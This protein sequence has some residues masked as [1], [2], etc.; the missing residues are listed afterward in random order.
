MRARVYLFSS[1]QRDSFA[2]QIIRVP[3]RSRPAIRSSRLGPI[4]KYLSCTHKSNECF[5]AINAT[6]SNAK[7]IPPTSKTPPVAFQKVC[8]VTIAPL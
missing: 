6:A 7:K 3:I 5:V 8:L 1:G 4:S 2:F